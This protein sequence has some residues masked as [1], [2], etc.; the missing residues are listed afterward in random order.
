VLSQPGLL[1]VYRLI[2]HL[3]STLG[4]KIQLL[5]DIQVAFTDT[6]GGTE[7]RDRQLRMASRQGNQTARETHRVR[8]ARWTSR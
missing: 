5:D 3:D 1:L 7:S 6:T 2:L 4:G 8:A